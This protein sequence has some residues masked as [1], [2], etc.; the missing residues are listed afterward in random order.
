[1]ESNVIKNRLTPRQKLAAAEMATGVS[2]TDAALLGKVSKQTIWRWQQLPDFQDYMNRRISEAEAEGDLRLR[3]MRGEAIQR[4]RS[5]LA[6]E[7]SAVALRATV[8]ILDRQGNI[9]SPAAGGGVVDL[10]HLLSSLGLRSA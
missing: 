3:A 9:G 1:M 10:R 5:F 6:D 7:N 2:L 8:E 4:L